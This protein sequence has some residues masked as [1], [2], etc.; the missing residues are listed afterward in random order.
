ML[1]DGWEETPRPLW[2]PLP[3]EPSP[4]GATPRRLVRHDEE[5]PGDDETAEAAASCAWDLQDPRRW[6]L[7]AEALAAVGQRLDEVWRRCRDGFR[8]RTRDPSA[9]ASH[10]LRGPWTLDPARHVANLA[11]NRT[12]D[13]G[14]ALQPCLAHSPW[15]GPAVCG[16][17]QA[18]SKATAA[19]AQGSTWMLEE[20][21]EEKAGRPK[22]GASRQDQGRRGQVA[23]CRVDTCLPSAHGGRWAMGEGARCVPEEWC[24]AACAQIRHEL[25]L[26]QARP[27]ATTIAVGLQRVTRVKA[28]GVPCDLVACDALYGRE[29]PCRAEVDPAGGRDAA[30]VPADTNV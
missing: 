7:S 8:T 30:Q 28:H 2:D 17:R 1:R 24:G 11:R 16:Q 20:R 9:N 19:L 12:G 23:G 13:D 29:S 5:R 27:C 4:A 26:P 3:L 22:A 6:G 21:A 15:S 18:A 25:G 14:Q 10:S